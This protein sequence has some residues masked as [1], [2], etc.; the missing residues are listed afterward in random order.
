MIIGMVH[1]CWPMR[2]LLS[3]VQEAM[4]LEKQKTK[5][6]NAPGRTKPQ[7][8]ETCSDGLK[9]HTYTRKAPKWTICHDSAAFAKEQRWGFPTTIAE[10]PAVFAMLPDI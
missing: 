1:R 7:I 9:T 10:S 8:Y 2:V 5:Q 4:E 6:K 3:F